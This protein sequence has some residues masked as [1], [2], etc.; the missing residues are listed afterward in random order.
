MGTAS[1]APTTLLNGKT[2]ELV[3]TFFLFHLLKYA[4]QV[5]GFWRLQWRK[6]LVRIEL[7]RVPSS[8]AAGPPWHRKSVSN[9]V[10]TVF[11]AYNALLWSERRFVAH[12]LTDTRHPSC[13]PYPIISLVQI[14]SNSK[15]LC[16]DVSAST[17][18]LGRII[19]LKV[20]GGG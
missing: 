17:C 8:T 4:V 16:V 7:N 6:L 20:P 3:V 13:M 10:E 2:D 14:K 9:S 1:A 19:R 11:A 5:V 12:A 18:E 15:V